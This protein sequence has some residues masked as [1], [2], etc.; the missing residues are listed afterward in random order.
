[1]IGVSMRVTPNAFHYQL[2]EEAANKIE[3]FY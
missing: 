2:R 1:M 3:T